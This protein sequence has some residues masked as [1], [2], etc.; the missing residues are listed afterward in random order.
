MIGPRMPPPPS[1][2]MV[3]SPP[4]FLRK[5]V[6]GRWSGKGKAML[7]HLGYSWCPSSPV[8]VGGGRGGGPHLSNF[9]NI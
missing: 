6:G 8:E 1:T 5:C 7:S 9:G 2:P 3:W 4:P